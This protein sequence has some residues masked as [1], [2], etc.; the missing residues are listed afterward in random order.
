M[1]LVQIL[2]VEITDIR[3]DLTDRFD[4]TFLC[5]DLNFRLD[6]SRLHADWL[7][8]RQGTASSLVL[9]QSA[10][11][12]YS[13]YKQAFEFDQLYALMKRGNFFNGF[14]EAPINFPPTF[15][16]DVLRTL[17]RSKT[18]SRSKLSILGDR[19]GQLT[20]VDEREIEE[21][22][23][24]DDDLEG[25][26]LAS[27]ALTSTISRPATEIGQEDEAYFYTSASSHITVP[28]EINAVPSPKP[29]K[30]KVK[31]FSLLSPSLAAFPSKLSKTK[32]ADLYALPLTPTV[33]TRSVP[34]S[35]LQATGPDVGR[36]RFLR[37]PPM[38]LVNS[39]GSENVLL[40]DANVEEKGVYD[41]SH[42]KRV[43]SWYVTYFRKS[44]VGL[45]MG[46]EGVIAFCGRQ[47]FNLILLTMTSILRNRDIVRAVAS[48]TFLP[49]LF[50][51]LLPVQH[52]TL[53]HCKA[54]GSC[55]EMRARLLLMP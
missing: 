40:G 7:I 47:L 26:S 55:L 44:F 29:N 51:Q 25:A 19:S 37:P 1:Y 14:S 41:S 36:R 15:K 45:L 52:G 28:G 38:I 53:P 49:M 22:E 6:I 5:G 11:I 42:K 3:A 13:E 20:E 34:P 9:S 16:Y 46:L 48:V 39:S 21:T 4:F 32:N 30:A 27:S 2:V 54:L 50:G 18:T 17:K 23:D 43:P 10:Q 8:A 12:F 24:Y 31:W 33:A 35:P